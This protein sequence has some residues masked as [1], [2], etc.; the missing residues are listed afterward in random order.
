MLHALSSGCLD[1]LLRE[2]KIETCNSCQLCNWVK[3]YHQWAG[4]E[5]FHLPC[6]G[7]TTLFIV[8]LIS[9]YLPT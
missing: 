6:I 5:Q 1:V 4:F 8:V 3:H 9:P 2:T 7:F